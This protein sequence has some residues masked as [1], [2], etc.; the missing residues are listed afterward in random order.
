MARGCA[1]LLEPDCPIPRA[2]QR[3]E[4]AHRMWHQTAANYADPRGFRQGLN[5]ILQSLR[6]GTW[7]LQQET[8]SGQEVQDWHDSWH[9]RVRGDEVLHWLVQTHRH[10]LTEEDLQPASTARVTLMVNEDGEGR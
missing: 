10:N 7:A 5:N 3:L 6:G 4:D 1:S 8:R 9:S 2:H